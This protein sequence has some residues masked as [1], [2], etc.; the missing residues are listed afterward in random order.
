MKRLQRRSL[1]MLPSGVQ[2]RAHAST[3]RQNRFARRYGLRMLS[4][5]INLLL[6]SVL[7]TVC[8]QTVLYMQESGTLT[9]PDAIRERAE[10]GQ[11]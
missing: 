1:R 4:V 5:S 6:A 8:Y 7:I 2:G 10:S 11:N 3:V 9:V